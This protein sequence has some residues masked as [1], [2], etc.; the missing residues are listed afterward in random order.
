MVERPRTPLRA[1][2]AVVLAAAFA[3]TVSGATAAP[4][5]TH[6]A[7]SMAAVS[8]PDGYIVTQPAVQTGCS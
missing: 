3:A 7:S 4:R 1:S 2:L 6:G 5:C 8:A